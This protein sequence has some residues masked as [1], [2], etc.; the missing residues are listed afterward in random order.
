MASQEISYPNIENAARS[1]FQKA[2]P[3]HDYCHTERVLATCISIGRKMN[4][5]IEILYAAALLH[6]IAREKADI[7]GE[8]H[9]RKS[10]EI[11]EP[12]L[13]K[14]GFPGEKIPAV[15]HCI[16]TH[17]FRSDNPPQSPEARI[18]YDADKLDAIGAIGVC[19]A[20][21]Y[22]GENGQRLYSSFNPGDIQTPS[23]AMP[24]RITN[25]DNHTPIMEFRMKL[26]RIKDNLFTKAAKDLAESRHRFMLRFFNRLYEEVNGIK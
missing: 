22:G 9:A 8:C 1:A 20:Y 17:R 4:A 19:R 23:K 25:H 3:T 15:L 7:T 24:S 16:A 5:D 13:E 18:L 26:S 11:A 12:I 14:S 10:A 6:D 2:P 21:A